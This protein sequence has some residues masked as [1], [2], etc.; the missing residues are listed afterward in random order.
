MQMK[1]FIFAVILGLGM[2]A[3]GADT[4]HWTQP[5]NI[6]WTE[7]GTKGL[8]SMPAG[9]GNIG[10]NGWAHNDAVVFYIWS[11]VSFNEQD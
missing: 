11:S 8:D 3:H 1:R 5:Y 9:G 2:A 4:P 10:L 6:V 7:P